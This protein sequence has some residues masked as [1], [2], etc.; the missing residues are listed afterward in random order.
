M[1]WGFY[2]DG[3]GSESGE[4]EGACCKA[5]FVIFEW[6]G[7]F[8]VTPPDVGGRECASYECMSFWDSDWGLWSWYERC[9]LYLWWRSWIEGLL[10]QGLIEA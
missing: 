3:G 1:G 10:G 7:G 8:L 4:L 5:G 6:E 2:D 9:C